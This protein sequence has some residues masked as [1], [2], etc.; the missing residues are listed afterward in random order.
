MKNMKTKFP[1]P[2]IVKC[3]IKE[4]W[5]VCNSS[6]TAKGIPTLMKKYYPGYTGHIASADYL[7]KLKNQLAN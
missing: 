7:E 5:I 2:H 6:I 4:V 3:D 1:L